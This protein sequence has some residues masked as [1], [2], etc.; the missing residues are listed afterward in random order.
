[1]CV[2]AGALQRGDGLWLMHKRPAQKH[3][4]GL[5]E[6]PGG[7]VEEYENQQE[8]LI[9]ELREELGIDIVLDSHVAVAEARDDAQHGRK[10]I[11]IALYTSRDWEGEPRALEGGRIEWFTPDQIRRLN[12]PPLDVML[13]DKL[14]AELADKGLQRR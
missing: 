6:F 9:R 1:M 11:V 4:G 2:V 10:S 7:K 13:A 12:K 3:H 14:F 5:W 8:A